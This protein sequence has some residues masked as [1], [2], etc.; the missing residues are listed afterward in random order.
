MSKLASC[1]LCFGLLL[2]VTALAQPPGPPGMPVKTEIVVTQNIQVNK[3]Q[4][5]IWRMIADGKISIKLGETYV[6]CFGYYQN[7]SSGGM[8]QAAI[9]QLTAPVQS[10]TTSSFQMSGTA[11][12][13]G[14]YRFFAVLEYKDAQGNPPVSIDDTKTAVC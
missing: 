4:Q 9:N 2:T 3:Q 7:T 13:S 10:G 8:V 6:G 1:F 12:F 5:S 11:T 14:T